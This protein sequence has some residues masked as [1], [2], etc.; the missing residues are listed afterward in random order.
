MLKFVCV[1]ENK[2]VPTKD[3]ELDSA[4]A[5]FCRGIKICCLITDQTSPGKES[6]VA[7]QPLE[8]RAK[9]EKHPFADS[10]IEWKEKHQSSYSE[11]PR[12][13]GLL[14]KICSSGLSA[15]LVAFKIPSQEEQHSRI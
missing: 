5:I 14:A 15:R 6:G 2:R 11:A 3:C 1:A 8:S 13:N 12:I 9:R 7:I 10:S 4:T